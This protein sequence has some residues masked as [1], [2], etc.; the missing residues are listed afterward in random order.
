MSAAMNPGEWPADWMFYTGNN[1]GLGADLFW[2]GGIA[3]MLWWH[4]RQARQS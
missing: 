2:L 4:F 3:V 1:T